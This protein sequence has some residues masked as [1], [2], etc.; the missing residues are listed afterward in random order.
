MNSSVSCKDFV[1]SFMEISVHF[2]EIKHLYYLHSAI[3]F[4][5]IFQFYTTCIKAFA[6]KAYI[7]WFGL[8]AN[9]VA[10][11]AGNWQNA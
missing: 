7:Q 2:Y 3:T 4:C 5:A 10:T 1:I 11:D 9:I 8:I 6:K